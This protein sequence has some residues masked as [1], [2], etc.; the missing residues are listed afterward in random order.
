MC[1]G[2]VDESRS[3]PAHH[4][5]HLRGGLPLADAINDKGST[6]GEKG[7]QQPNK[8]I[9][10]ASWTSCSKDI[11]YLL[12]RKKII[13]FFRRFSCIK[14]DVY[15][16]K[17]SI[18]I[19][20]LCCKPGLHRWK[21]VVVAW[22]QIWAIRRMIKHFPLKII[23]YVMYDWLYGDVHCRGKTKFLSS[24]FPYACFVLFFV[25][26]A[27]FTVPLCVDCCYNFSR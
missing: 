24:I 23:Q 25:G 3:F 17:V 8:W 11:Q 22:C 19:E 10:L 9:L 15:R 26:S 2:L 18:T 5:L 27:M 13:V 6:N 12:V 4:Y 1:R 16:E 7:R 21:E 14:E 20:V